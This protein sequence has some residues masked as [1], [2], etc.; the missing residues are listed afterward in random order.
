MLKLF[1]ILSTASMLSRASTIFPTLELSTLDGIIG[2]R[3]NGVSTGDLSGKSVASAGDM[4]GDGVS[5]LI[6]GAYDAA[7]GG[8][9]GAGS[10]F[11]VFGTSAGFGAALE[12]STLNGANGFRINGVSAGD[13]SGQSVASAGDINGDGLGDLIIGAPY[14]SPGNRTDAGSSFVVFGTNKSFGGVLE[15]STLNGTNGFRI[16]GVSTG[17]FS[18]TV[19][20]AGDMNGD[21]LSDLII[22]ASQ[23]DPGGRS[24]AGSSFVVFGTNKSFGGVLELSTLNGTNGFRINGVLAGDW[25]G[26][27]VASAGDMNN[28]GLSDLIIGADGAGPGGRV[29]AGSSFIVF[30]TNKSF[31]GA[32]E[33]STL[34]GTEGFRIN[35]V[36]AY[37]YSGDGS[38]SVASAGDIN[39]DGLGDLII[40]AW[41]ASPGGRNQAGSSFIVFGTNKSFG[42][43]LELSTLNG[44]NG[45]RI[46]GVSA[47]DHSGFFGGCAGDI[48]GDGLSD[49]IIGADRASPG[50]RYQAGSS[51]IVFGTNKSFGAALEL[52]ALNGINGFRI[53]GVSA[54]DL[55]GN[56]VAGAGDMNND[57]LSDLII[58]VLYASPSGLTQA[59]SSFLVFGDSIQQG[60]NQL[61][62]SAGA[63]QILTPFSLN[64][65]VSFRPE[66][67]QY[68]ISEL[69]HGRFEY[70]TNP[71][72]AITNFSGQD[73]MTGRV[74]FTHD[75]SELAPSYL[76]TAS[77][78]LATIIYPA[79]ITFIN[80]LPILV[81]NSLTISQGQTVQLDDTML[82][83][84]DPD[85]PKHD[86]DIVFTIFGAS[87]GFF[88]SYN[89]SQ[90][91]LWNGSVSF[92]QDNSASAPQYTVNI[93]RGGVTQGP[94]SPTIN[95][96][97]T[98]N[99]NTV[100][101]VLLGVTAVASTGSLLFFV[102]PWVWKKKTKAQFQKMALE[103]TSDAEKA[104]NEEVVRPIANKI[105][106]VMNTTGFFGRRTEAETKAYMMAIGKIIAELRRQNANLDFNAMEPVDKESFLNEIASQTRQQSLPKKKGFLGNC[107]HYCKA[108]ATPQEIEYG[109]EGIAVAAVAWQNRHMSGVS[110]KNTSLGLTLGKLSSIKLPTEA[111]NEGVPPEKQFRLMQNHMKAMEQQRVQE[112]QERKILEE[113]LAQQ[114]AELAVF[115]KQG[116]Q[117][118]TC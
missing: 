48:N 55:S 35:S 4:N 13:N 82:A 75:D 39:G 81:N 41:G 102:L 20:S 92:T 1:T 112:Q 15:L 16:N 74:K 60:V 87:N 42:A 14:A 38:G 26:R 97:N 100:R 56:S 52:S 116:T 110:A 69:Q 21:G 105:F 80:Q 63:S 23:A 34:N 58:G 22:G 90:R 95:F 29:Q 7:P 12:L 104:F 45:F 50:G 44:A 113:R 59:G 67:T 96:A 53:N 66:Y 77:H 89:F 61:M 24:N 72:I 83:A 76:V 117:A 27:S 85:N 64:A 33:L 99:S 84:V 18:G 114:E 73:L 2:T 57:G 46:N 78:T 36:S 54:G 19:A 43:V 47:D 11:V 37:D 68:A 70:T 40:G 106:N 115:R 107:A 10:S 17:D 65:T 79:N 25:S 86:A 9:V 108:E 51:F 31:G 30:G 32:L 93:T 101:N 98:E 118:N 71:G 94:Y 62:I 109:A 91:A 49:L 6:I 111:A 8:Q 88:S 28:D 5:D 3:F 103:G